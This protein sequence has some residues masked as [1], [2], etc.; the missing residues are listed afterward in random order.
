[1]NGYRSS[2]AHGYAIVFLLKRKYLTEAAHIDPCL[3]GFLRIRVFVLIFE[4]L[5]HYLVALCPVGQALAAVVTAF[6]ALHE[7]VLPHILQPVSDL[8]FNAYI[9]NLAKPV[10]GLA[11]S[12]SV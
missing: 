8:P 11:R 10:V 6:L 2:D 3:T 7:N 9:R 5:L 12:V 1:M 4:S